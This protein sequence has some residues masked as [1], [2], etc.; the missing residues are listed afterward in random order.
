MYRNREVKFNPPQKK[1]EKHRRQLWR[2]V[3]SVCAACL[4]FIY[5]VEKLQ[6]LTLYVTSIRI[7]VVS[8]TV[9]YPFKRFALRQTTSDARPYIFNDLEGDRDDYLFIFI[10][11]CT[12]IHI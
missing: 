10:C 7:S 1:N 5:K 12:Y 8:P 9:C 2:C 11:I 6:W 3:F 4:G